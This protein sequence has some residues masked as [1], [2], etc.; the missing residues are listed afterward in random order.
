MAGRSLAVLIHEGL[1]EGA[2]LLHSLHGHPVV[3]RR[4]AASDRAVPGE[5]VELLLL[6]AVQELLLQLLVAAL[7]GEGEVHPGAGRL[8]NGAL[9]EA[10]GPVDDVIDEAALLCGLLRPV[11][12]TANLL[13][14]LQVLPHDV[15]G[16]AGRRVVHRAILRGHLPA[17]VRG[18]DLQFVLA[19]GKLR[20]DE[21]HGDAGRAQVL[22]QACI[23]VGVLADIDRLGA[24][25]RGHVRNKRHTSDVWGVAE[26]HAVHRLVGAVVHVGG[27][28]VQ[29]PGGLVRDAG[30]L[31]GLRVASNLAGAV[32]GSLLVRLLA[33]LPGDEVVRLSL[34]SEHVQRHGGELERGSTLSQD[35]LVV[36]RHA[37]DVAQVLLG[38]SGN[39]HELL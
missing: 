25:V 34:S 26:F 37:E 28:W 32:L 35:D 33:P 6:C 9:E 12:H 11:C 16:E 17:A 3:Q 21:A 18:A 2:E 29:L 30:E 24:E 20:A 27:L 38:L 23:D 7:D 22:L 19:C 14:V 4:A 39:L 31:G 15:H 36:V 10:V 13:G 8:L 1:H 5:R